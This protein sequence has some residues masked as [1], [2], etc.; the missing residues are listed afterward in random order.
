MIG[1][2]MDIQWQLSLIQLINFAIVIAF[3]G[4]LAFLVIWDSRRRGN[5]KKAAILWTFVSIFLF[6]FGILAYLIMRSQT[7]NSQ[8]SPPAES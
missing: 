1:N 5:S 8:K 3:V 2:K 4:G 6:P 7:P